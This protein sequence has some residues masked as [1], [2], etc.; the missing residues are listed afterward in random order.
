MD[1]EHRIQL[2]SEDAS[3]IGILYIMLLDFM[4]GVVTLLSQ[5]LLSR[6]SHYKATSQGTTVP[7]DHD[8]QG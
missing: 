8:Y 3:G 2:E 5:Q 4:Y 6:H 7:L 1:R